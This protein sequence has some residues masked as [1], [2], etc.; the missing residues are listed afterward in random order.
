MWQNLLSE[1]Y[2][3]WLLVSN[4]NGNQ[5]CTPSVSDTQA[6]FY[7]MVMSIPVVLSVE[8]PGAL[9]AKCKVL[10]MLPKSLLS[11]NQSSLTEYRK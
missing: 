6:F 8:Q 5:T 7:L 11:T 2:I 10:S 3:L 4:G 1:T 9:Q